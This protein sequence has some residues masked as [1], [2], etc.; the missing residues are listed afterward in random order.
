M[1]RARGPRTHI[2]SPRPYNGVVGPERRATDV[3]PLML[4]EMHTVEMVAQSAAM[5]MFYCQPKLI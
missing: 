1:P 2:R 5:W 4:V 3:V